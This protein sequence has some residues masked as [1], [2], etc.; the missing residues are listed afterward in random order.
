[1]CRVE[2]GG[3]EHAQPTTASAANSHD[4]EISYLF[5]GPLMQ[6]L[7]QRKTKA[8]PIDACPIDR[9]SQ[10]PRELLS[11][12]LN[13]L[14]TQSAVHKTRTKPSNAS[15]SPA[16]AADVSTPR[17]SKAPHCSAAAGLD[18]ESAILTNPP[19]GMR[20]QTQSATVHESM[21]DQLIPSVRSDFVS[22]NRQPG[23]LCHKSKTAPCNGAA[24]GTNQNRQSSPLEM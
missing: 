24:T 8:C 18:F 20:M 21:H 15:K 17:P 13:G 3:S 19:P 16:A 9:P 1:V 23:K 5:T 12:F 22:R 14:V 11:S 4:R 7:H 6:V 2:S 10:Y